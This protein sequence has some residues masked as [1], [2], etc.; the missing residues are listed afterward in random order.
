MA[1]IFRILSGFCRIHRYIGLALL[2][3][4]AHV[5]YIINS[6]FPSEIRGE[7]I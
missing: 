6:F 1:V 5:G 4:Y 3:I 2:F 7:N